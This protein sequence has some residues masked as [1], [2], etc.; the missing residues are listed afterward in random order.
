MKYNKNGKESKYSKLHTVQSHKI[1]EVAY[2]LFITRS[3]NEVRMKDIARKAKISRQTLCKYF[4][5][6]DDVIFAIQDH[7]ISE[8][9][10]AI[11]QTK[12][13]NANGRELLLQTQS[14]FF[15]YGLT[16]PDKLFFVSLF[17]NYNRNRPDNDPL[18]ARY[19][20]TLT[21]GPLSQD[22]IRVGQ[23]D[24]SIRSDVDPELLSYF[25][26]NQTI[27]L[28][29]RFATAG[30]HAFPRDGSVSPEAMEKLYLETVDRDLD[31]R[32]GVKE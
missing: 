10:T 13:E 8:M 28:A 30:K 21:D 31:P 3:F 14:T 24:G 1:I 19:H 4:P 32:I 27:A 25:L 9:S 22:F 5:S 17:E 18:N 26:H 12:P 15:H 7:I 29:L 2:K 6:I 23:A 16:H 20:Q 11:A